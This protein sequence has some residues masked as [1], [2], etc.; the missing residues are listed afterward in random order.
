MTTKL[1][2][3][4]HPQAQLMSRIL[5]ATKPITLCCAVEVF[6]QEYSDRVIPGK[7][8]FLYFPC[9]Y[10]IVLQNGSK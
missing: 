9:R 1:L 10:K 5:G 6:E 8:G 3:L 4:R 7:H 2:L